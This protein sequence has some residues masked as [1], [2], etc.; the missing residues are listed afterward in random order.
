LLTVAERNATFRTNRFRIFEFSSGRENR[1][2]VAPK[3]EIVPDENKRISENSNP[4]NFEYL[5]NKKN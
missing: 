1:T 3:K 4:L 5:S 2:T